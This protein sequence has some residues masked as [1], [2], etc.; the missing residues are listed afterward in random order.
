MTMLSIDKHLLE[1]LINQS[2]D[3]VYVVDAASGLVLYGNNKAYGNLGCCRE[4]LLR[5]RVRD[6]AEMIPDEAAWQRQV[7]RMRKERRAVFETRHRRRNGNWLPVEV[8]TRFLVLDGQEFI[9]SVVRDITERKKAEAALVAEKNKLESVISALGDGLTVQDTEYR[10]LYQNAVHREKQ[11]DHVGEYC[12]R[13]YQHRE[14]ICPGCVLQKSFA[15]GQIHR[16]ETSARSGNRVIHMEVSASPLRDADGVI[17]GGIEVVRDITPRKELELQLRHA[18]K[19]QAIGTLAGGVAH[20]FNNILFAM[21][22]NTEMAMRKLAQDDPTLPLL[23]DVVRAGKRAAELVRQILTF[24]QKAEQEMRPLALQEVVREVVRLLK[25]TL[26]PSIELR[27]RI[28]DGCGL[29]F[30]DATQLHQLVMNLAINGYHAMESE[31]GRLE[32]GLEEVADEEA[33]D[34]RWARLSV[35][36]TGHGMDEVTLDRIFEP[37]FATKEAGRGTGLGLALVHGIV[38]AHQGVIQVHSVP[39]AGTTFEVRFPLHRVAVVDSSSSETPVEPASLNVRV[40]F[41]DDEEMLVRLAQLALSELGCVVTAVANPLEALELFVAAPERFD[42]MI[43]DQAMPQMSGVELARKVLA[44]RP[45]LP[46]ILCTGYAAAMSAQAAREVGISKVVM[47]PLTL[48]ALSQLIWQLFTSQKN[49]GP[50]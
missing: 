16:R 39:G 2:N 4:E 1:N 8:S 14:N 19:M 45:E 26:P 41:V 42:L 7:E 23:A 13:A 49:C 25:A 33:P 21:L 43:T 30:G 12:Y 32:I 9:V 40:L 35:V 5:L 24:S 11:G 17:V 6:F 27:D 22:G 3:A 34:T 31:G 36:D 47:K 48:E 44:L 38:K 29:I 15:D 28:A 20:D 18:Q 46:I 10:I 50:Q 37:Y